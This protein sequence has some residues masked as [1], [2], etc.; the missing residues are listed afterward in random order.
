MTSAPRTLARAPTTWRG[1]ARAATTSLGLALAVTAVPLPARAADPVTNP[2]PTEITGPAEIT[3]T[4]LAPRTI[5][6]GDPVTVQARLT[7]AGT[8]P[9]SRLRV[10]LRTGARLVT[11]S[12]LA[13]A[14]ADPPPDSH[15]AGGWSELAAG[16]PARRTMSIRYQT[17][18]TALGLSRIGVYP[19]ELVVEGENGTGSGRQQVGSVRTYL[20]YLAGTVAEPTE[21]SWLIPLVDR[22]HRLTEESVFSDDGLAGELGVHGR[23][24]NLLHLARVADRAHVPFTLAVDPDLIDSVAA[25]RQGYTVQ[26]GRTRVDGTGRQSATQWMSQLVS[27]TGSG[28]HLVFALPYGDAD[29][30]AVVQAGLPGLAQTQ[31]ETV[32]RLSGQLQTTVSTQVAWPDGGLLTDRALDLVTRNQ[33]AVVLASAALSQPPAGI[34]RDAT[35]PLGSAAGDAV[36]LVADAGLAQVLADAGTIPGGPR[37]AEQR[38]LAE[39]AMITAEQPSVRR[40][41]LL[42]PPHRWAPEP[43]AAAAML[44]DTATVPW[45]AAGTVRGLITA[46]Q[47]PR[48]TLVYPPGAPSISST[49]AGRVRAVQTQVDDFRSAL[50]NAAANTLLEPFTHALGRAAS[51]TWRDDATAGAGFVYRLGARIATF[52][53]SV[54]IVRPDIGQYTLGGQRSD[55]PLTVVNELPVPVQVKIAITSRSGGG[56]RARN[57]GV[58]TLA[59]RRADGPPRRVQLRIPVTLTRSG[60]LQVSAGLTTPDGRPLSGPVPLEVQSNA[61]G[62]VALGITGAALVLLVLLV[63]RRVYRRV[64]R[65]PDAEPAPAGSPAER[66]T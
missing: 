31:R 46:P 51:S 3:V 57:T 48:G 59:A 9:L 2:R 54:Y 60:R 45:L 26:V 40:R 17:T 56:L 32:S 21:V 47:V 4:E 27:L 55:L 6:P 24:T 58:V 34:T 18:A 42:A 16:L 50:D 52:R 23:L 36:G 8:T 43:G 62:T 64:Q 20:P 10:Q 66:A 63:A 53:K 37:L 1:L 29:T 38:Y 65:G 15:G 35:S 30:V 41:V 14:D 11:R 39:L 28:R 25:M 33:E 49:Q 61:Y 44:V 12:A 7:N 13:D 22:P 5:R 19:A